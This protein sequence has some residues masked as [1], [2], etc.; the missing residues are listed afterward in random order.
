MDYSWSF[1]I[2]FL[3]FLFIVFISQA[4]STITKGKLPMPL[5]FGL[6]FIVGFAMGIL[7]KDMILSSNMIAVGT[8]AF[9]VL[10]I[11]SGTM[12]KIGF[13]AKNKNRALLC[14]CMTALAT[15]AAFLLSPIIGRDLALLSPGAVVGGGASCAIGSRWVLDVNP[16]ISVFPWLI[17]MAQGLFSAPILSWALKKEADLTLANLPENLTPPRPFSREM[18][19]DKIPNSF[20]TTAYYLLTIMLVAV[21]N[22]FLHATILSSFDINLNITGLLFGIILGN[23]GFMDTAPLQKADSFGL[24]LLGLMGLMA[25]TMANTPIYAITALL[26]PLAIVMI[27]SVAVLFFGSVF[28]SKK[29]GLSKYEGIILSINS[30]TGFAMNEM[31]IQHATKHIEDEH[32]KIFVKAKLGP[33]M[34][35]PTGLISNGLSIVLIGVL[36]SLI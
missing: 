36:V 24:L 28:L 25:N 10:V 2:S 32:K 20:K 33:I 29:L 31:L 27:V 7:P 9:N 19:I 16:S 23:I 26:L 5:T 4:I 14:I 15:I 13:V 21:F 17:F 3:I 30:I 12:L 18:P 35:M 11:H 8:I 22:K 34:G 6:I 1:E